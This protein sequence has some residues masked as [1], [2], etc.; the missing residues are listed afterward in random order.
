MVY[1][2]VTY[3]SCCLV[4]AG[5]SEKSV[6]AKRMNRKHRRGHLIVWVVCV[7]ILVILV[8]LADRGRLAPAPAQT[9]IEQPSAAGVLP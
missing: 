2:L 3:A 1:T 9:N 4:V 7:P 6:E 8:Y 5:P